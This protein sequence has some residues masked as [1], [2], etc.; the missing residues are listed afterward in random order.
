MCAIAV[1][2]SS[3]RRSGWVAIEPNPGQRCTAALKSTIRLLM[4]TGTTGPTSAQPESAASST[5][6]AQALGEWIVSFSLD[7]DPRR[8]ELLERARLHILD[9]IG[10]A[11]AAS[12]V[13]DGMARPLRDVVTR[14]GTGGVARLIGTTARAAPPL[15]ALFN[16]SLI[17]SSEHDDTSYERIVHCEAFAIA[18]ILAVGE[19]E[20]SSGLE[21]AEAFCVGCETALR[22]ARGCSERHALWLQ[23]FHSTSVFGC[24]GC[25]AAASKLL[26][27]DAIATTNALALATSFTSGTTAGWAEGS[28]RNKTLQPGWAALS[29]INAALLAAAGVDCAT[30]TIDGPHGLFEAHAYQGEWSPAPVVRDL[31]EDWS[32]MTLT[33]KIHAAGSM[34]QSTLDALERL[35]LE[36]DVAPEEVEEV[37]LV[38]PAQWAP[39][40][41]RYH[42][43][44]YH[45]D[46]PYAIAF[47]WPVT[48]ACMILH[49]R[50]GADHQTGA[51]LRDPTLRA[52]AQKVR[53][54]ADTDASLP[55]EDQPSRVAVRTTR[56]VFRDE[57]KRN[58][59]YYGPHLGE[60][61]VRKF[62]ANARLA[63]SPE[64]SD[65]LR[66]RLLAIESTTAGEIGA[67]SGA[68]EE[69]THA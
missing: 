45:P 57:Q 53:Y 40:V 28:G 69:S 66:D 44:S 67:L 37:D 50:V 16:G 48:A 3:D 26:G 41:R 39:M 1:H 54:R 21:L 38:V 23:G 19:S 5:P 8:D 59:G 2:V 29:G 12:S 24:F 30:T 61:V 65:E 14:Y 15:A 10:V 7:D 27:L 47:S 52:L 35:V 4:P 43:E 11:L 42:D 56:G 36:H 49:R 58:L 31:G 9:G 60:R 33:F 22:L 63:L 51:V 46:S 64:R 18:T 55:P 6:I 25:A 20:H 62:D 34:I 68:P 32:L 13:P 17:H